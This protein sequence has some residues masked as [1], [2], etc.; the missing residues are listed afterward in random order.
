MKIVSIQTGILRRFH[1]QPEERSWQSGIHKE[2]RRSPVWM[3][4]VKLDGDHQADL[5]HHGGVDKAVNVYPIEH[6]AHW[7][8]IA[9]LASLSYGGFG[10]NFTTQGLTEKD[11]CIGDIYAIGLA[12]VQVSQPRQP[13]WKLSRRWGIKGLARQIERTGFTG[14]YVRVLQEGM[15]E[16]GMP[17]ELLARPFPKLTISLANAIMFKRIRDEVLVHTLALCPVL[18]E[19]W[20]SVLMKR[21]Q[22]V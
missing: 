12:R 14:W 20:R 22:G 16:T 18:S 17:L 4:K 2:P 6:Y 8:R 5:T 7:R 19:S 10:E 1:E 21:V 11:V 9:E 15:V 3:G 13:C